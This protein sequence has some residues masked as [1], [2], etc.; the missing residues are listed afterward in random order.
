M[1]ETYNNIC[2]ILTSQQ[3]ACLPCQLS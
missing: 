3:T 1:L 2:K